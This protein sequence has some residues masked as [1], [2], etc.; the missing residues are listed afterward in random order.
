VAIRKQE[1]YEGAALHLLARTGGI[2]SVR[3]EAP[4]FLVNQLSVLLKYSTRARSPWG[5][6][7]RRMSRYFYTTGRLN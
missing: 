1:F 5:S 2:T 3:Y 6:L 4:F 7:S